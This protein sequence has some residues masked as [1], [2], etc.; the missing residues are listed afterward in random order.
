MAEMKT[1]VLRNEVEKAVEKR[2]RGKRDGLQDQEEGESM[3]GEVRE[4]KAKYWEWKSK[5]GIEMERIE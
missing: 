1:L 5:L 3:K 2:E 4:W